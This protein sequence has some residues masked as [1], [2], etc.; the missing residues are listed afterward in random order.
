M[1]LKFKEIYIDWDFNGGIIENDLPLNILVEV[2]ISYRK[3]SVGSDMFFFTACNPSGL[4]KYL[5]PELELNKN[6][7]AVLSLVKP[8]V[9][10]QISEE[11]IITWINQLLSKIN[12]EE[13]STKDAIK[14]LCSY[15]TWEFEREAIDVKIDRVL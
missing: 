1:H 5:L 13:Q 14:E 2:H 3:Q 6:G 11:L 9:F 12:K 15:M 4:N 8:V 10:N 7:Y